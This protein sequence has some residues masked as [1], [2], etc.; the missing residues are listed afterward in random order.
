VS[1]S[2]A[3]PSP[4]AKPPDM[5]PEA[6]VAEL[7]KA[8][9]SDLLVHTTSLLAS[10]A[11]GKLAPEI[12]DLEQARL[13]IDALDALAPLLEEAPR[14]DVHQVVSSLKLAYADAAA[15]GESE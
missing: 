8:K 14:R 3:E 1:E 13:A 10:L 7:Q 12:R 15:A 6:L 11:Y 4:G 2:P 9:V 5:S